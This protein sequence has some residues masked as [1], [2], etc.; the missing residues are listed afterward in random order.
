[1]RPAKMMVKP[2]DA[3]MFGRSCP[4]LLSCTFS[5]AVVTVI[6]TSTERNAP[7]RFRMPARI[8]AVLGFRAPV[9]IEVAI[10]LPVS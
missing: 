7:T 2:I 5:T 4:V 3:S 6:A 10:A 9:A 8:T 1:M